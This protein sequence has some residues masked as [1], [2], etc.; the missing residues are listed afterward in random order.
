[1]PHR[2]LKPTPPKST[3][4]SLLYQLSHSLHPLGYALSIL[5]LLD[6]RSLGGARGSPVIQ[7]ALPATHS[8]WHPTTSLCLPC[9]KPGLGPCSSQKD[10]VTTEAQFHP[11]FAKA[12]SWSGL[13]RGQ[14]QGL[15]T[16]LY[17]CHQE[18]PDCSHFYQAPFCS[19]GVACSRCHQPLAW[20]EPPELLGA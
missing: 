5:T 20:H 10:P 17:I 3:S 6:H 2:H 4:R 9:P 15:P 18:P 7:W 8:N 14:S 1:M 16:A 19:L 11:F 13:T 12:Y